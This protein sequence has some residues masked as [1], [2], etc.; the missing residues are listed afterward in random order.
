MSNFIDFKY[1]IFTEQEILLLLSKIN[2]ID[3]FKR[4]TL[5]NYCYSC[6]TTNYNLNSLMCN[7]GSN[8]Y[9]F[10]DSMTAVLYF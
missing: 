1:S 5:P 10:A 3:I 7:C 8:L 2:K 4:T 9:E 6:K